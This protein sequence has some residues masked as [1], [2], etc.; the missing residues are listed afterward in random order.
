MSNESFIKYYSN[1]FYNNKSNY[2]M[3]NCYKESINLIGYEHKLD[4]IYDKLLLNIESSYKYLKNTFSILYF[5]TNQSHN[6]IYV[7]YLLD[8]VY[9]DNKDMFLKTLEDWYNFFEK[10]I[11][12]QF[13]IFFG[14]MFFILNKFYTK[15]DD[16]YNM[17][18]IIPEYDKIL[19]KIEAKYKIEI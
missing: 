10:P 19:E 9:L 17:N 1:I 11:E 16:Y 6:L 15:V 7:F 4:K 13:L 3:C 18:T 2:T 8:I 5:S 14:K 12:L